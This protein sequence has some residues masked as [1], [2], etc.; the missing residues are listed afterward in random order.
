VFDLMN[1][2]FVGLL[3]VAALLVVVLAVL[4]HQRASQRRHDLFALATTHGLTYSR[5]DPFGLASLPFRFLRRGDDRGVENVVHGT[6]GD[7]A[8]TLFDLW[9]RFDS[10]DAKGNRSSRTERWTCAYLRVSDVYWPRLQLSDENL[11]TRVGDAIGMR[12]LQLESD[13]FNRRWNVQA[14]DDRAAYAIRD[15]RMMRFL[16]DVERGHRFEIVGGDL[17]VM[18]RQLE[19]TRWLTLQ[20]MLRAFRDR[21]PAVA[22]DLYPAP[23]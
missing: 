6:L 17:L 21:I 22:I 19:P 4:Q 8:V 3:A 7:H 16:L 18:C 14:S 2:P 15:A 23:E 5:R 13:E 10:H 9:Q 11:F 20:H 12:D 1:V